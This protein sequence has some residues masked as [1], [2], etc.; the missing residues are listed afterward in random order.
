MFSIGY[1]FIQNYP[2][3]KYPLKGDKPEH[4]IWEQVTVNQLLGNIKISHRYRLEQRFHSSY[5]L[6]KMEYDFSQITHSNRFR[7]KITIKHPIGWKYFAQ[8]FCELWIASDSH[9]NN[10]SFDRNWIYAGLGRRFDNGLSV[11]VAY[12]HQKI[13]VKEELYER[14]PTYRL[15]LHVQ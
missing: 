12:L 15:P 1:S 2:Y 7:Y 9:L 8:A 6:N 5:N 3:G 14:H 4:N 13:K 10:T 11:Q